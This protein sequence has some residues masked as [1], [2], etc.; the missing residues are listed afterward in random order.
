MMN[1]DEASSFKATR[2]STEC[3]RLCVS[4]CVCMCVRVCHVPAKNTIFSTSPLLSNAF[5]ALILSPACCDVTHTHTTHIHTHSHTHMTSQRQWRPV[6]PV[7]AALRPGSPVRCSMG[8]K[9]C[10]AHMRMREQHGSPTSLNIS[11]TH[12]HTY[13]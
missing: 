3:V 10:A 7:A 2:K 12:T 13:A 1:H 8:Y 6:H 5:M 9:L 4:V 11:A